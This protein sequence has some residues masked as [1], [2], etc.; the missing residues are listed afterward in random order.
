[1]SGLRSADVSLVCS[2][3]IRSDLALQPLDREAPGAGKPTDADFQFVLLARIPGHRIVALRPQVGSNIGAAKA[4]RDEMIDLELP[5]SP[6]DSIFAVDRR[7]EISRGV[8]HCLRIA[9]SAD[10]HEI[11]CQDRPGRH[12]WIGADRK[13]L[14][15][16]GPGVAKWRDDKSGASIFSD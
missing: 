11:R 13:I 6:V 8:A 3:P 2:N 15:L 10:G 4:E 9:G 16:T 12:L 5:A 7:L 14:G 1:M